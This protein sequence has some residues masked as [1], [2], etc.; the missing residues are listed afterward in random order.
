M[1]IQREGPGDRRFGENSFGL[2]CSVAACVVG[3]ASRLSSCG[4]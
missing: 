3:T 4:Q 2:I 1:A